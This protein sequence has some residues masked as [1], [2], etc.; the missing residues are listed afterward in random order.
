MNLEHTDATPCIPGYR[1]ER[2]IACGG[3]ATVYLATQLDLGRTVALKVLSPEHTPDTEA[4]AR[5]EQETRTIA[6]LNHPHIVGIHE[7]GRTDDGRLY[8][9]MPFLPHEDLA[10]RSRHGRPGDVMPV[11]RAL[12]GA[13]DY[14]HE[15]GV[16]HRDVK[17]ANVMFDAHDQPLLA[18]FGIA[19]N[20]REDLRVTR[21][22]ATV[23]SS[24]YMSPE[25]ARGLIADRRSDIYSAGV[26]LYELLTGDMPYEGP[27]ALSVAIAHAEDPVPS[28]PAH[29]SAWQEV[30]DGALAKRSEDRF[31]SAGQMLDALEAAA[32]RAR[33]DGQGSHR[34]RQWWRAVRYRHQSGILLG[35][36]ALLA[37]VATIVLLIFLRH[38]RS[39]PVALPA[40][41]ASIATAVSAPNVVLSTPMLSARELDRLLAS[42][43]TKLHAGA[44]IKPE[45][46]N[47]A[48]DFQRILKAYPNNPE[49]LSGMNAVLD[50]LG[51]R[52]E[53]A[54]DRGDTRQVFKLYQQAQALANHGGIR[55]QPFWSAFVDRINASVA[56]TLERSAHATPEH[57]A[58]LQK[59]ATAFDQSLPPRAPP[60]APARTLHVGAALHDP[61]GPPLVVVSLAP[62]HAYAVGRHAVT[63]AQYA[64]FVAASHRPA[65]DC[66]KLG[67]VFSAMHHWSW[68][69]PGF[70]QD[71]QAPVVCIS[72]RDARAYLG[73]LAQTSGKHYRL[74]SKTEWQA[75]H[76]LSGKTAPAYPAQMQEWLRCTD[77][78]ARV[79]Y[80]GKAEHGTSKPDRGYT[81]VGFRVVRDIDRH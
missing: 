37:I 2:T 7:V 43:N 59:L 28:L 42:G 79:D 75:A 60:P 51:N 16:I 48:N 34:L 38:S 69:D 65:S 70:K 10:A 64:R 67:N 41:S 32:V 66:R 27:D 21:V 50:T 5:F 80:R 46:D 49:A 72:W 47:A 71:D 58:D 6:Q 9:S 14:A 12:L 57:R 35:G 63:R 4:V 55:K 44:L 26:M 30:I 62:R 52:I 74:P 8:Y 68:Q 76:R 18:D 73:W 29:L 31:S 25:Q 1:I 40:P 3:M 23:G 81:S 61:S 17:P 53:H 45:N 20:T 33:D 77:G 36:A 56:K 13:L 15:Q 39:T 24:G 78:C 11:M 22:G 19:L 54:L